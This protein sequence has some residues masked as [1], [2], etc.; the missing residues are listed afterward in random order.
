MFA[1]KS[2]FANRFIFYL[3]TKLTPKRVYFSTGKLGDHLENHLGLTVSVSKHNREFCGFGKYL[4]SATISHWPEQMWRRSRTPRLQ[5][6]DMIMTVCCA[7]VVF[8]FQ[9]PHQ[10]RRALMTTAQ[11]AESPPREVCIRGH[12]HIH[13][14]AT[15]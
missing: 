2:L 10:S 9:H 6:P 7:R 8:T 13:K 12:T 15:V 4:W 11:A 1:N 14:R 3:Q 5:T